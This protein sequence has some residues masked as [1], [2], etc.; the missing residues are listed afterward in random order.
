MRQAQTNTTTE[1]QLTKK[2]RMIQLWSLPN[3]LTQNKQIEVEGSLHKLVLWG[4]HGPIAIV[5]G[6]H[7]PLMYQLVQR[8]LLHGLNLALYRVARRVADVVAQ[9]WCVVPEAASAHGGTVALH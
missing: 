9:H 4:L 8:H 6:L 1:L 5:V 7:D 3:I 2:Q